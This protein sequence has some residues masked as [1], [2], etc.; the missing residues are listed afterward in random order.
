MDETERFESDYDRTTAS[1]L[2]IFKVLVN[3]YNKVCYNSP[4]VRLLRI[5]DDGKWHSLARIRKEYGS[6]YVDFYLK[7]TWV[8]YLT[9]KSKQ[10][11]EVLYKITSKGEAFLKFVD[12]AKMVLPEG[13]SI[14]DDKVFR[15]TEL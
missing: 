10:G 11:R 1:M 14:F 13:T 6:K 12:K 15:L 4:F 9:N 5:L 3:R 8:W 2:D 7:V